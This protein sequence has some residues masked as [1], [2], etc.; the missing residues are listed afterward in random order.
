MNSIGKY[1]ILKELGAGGFGA[2][3]LCEDQLG[4]QVAIKIFKP[5]DNTVAGA[6]TSATSDAGDV[7]KKRFKEE[8]RILHQLSDNAYIVNFMAYDEM[9]DGTPYLR[10]AISHCVFGR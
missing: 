10:Y 7:L 5:Q 2:V 9:E 4:Q 6:A 8:A 3:Y 1:K